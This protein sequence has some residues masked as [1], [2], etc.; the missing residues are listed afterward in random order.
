[1]TYM[2]RLGGMRNELYPKTM[3]NA[4]SS[5]D[6]VPYKEAGEDGTRELSRR[7]HNWIGSK[8]RKADGWA[9]GVGSRLLYQSLEKIISVNE[10]M[11]LFESDLF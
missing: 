5:M 10:Y 8:Y 6:L 2:E 1:M 3:Y 4:L 11:D 7:K 9:E